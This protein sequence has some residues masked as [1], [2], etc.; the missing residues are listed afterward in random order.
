MK[1]RKKVNLQER[2]S[3]FTVCLIL[4][5]VLLCSLLYYHTLSNTIEKQLSKRALNVATTIAL[6]PEIRDAFYTE[7]P[8][9]IIQPIVEQIREKIDAEYI[10]VGNKDGIRYSHPIPE[11]IGKQMIGGDNAKALKE[12]RSYTSIATGSL[13]LSLRGKVPIKGQNGEI[14]G[15]VSVGFLIEDVHHLVSKHAKPIVWI[16]LC[17]LLIGMIGSI[18]LVKSIKKIMFGLEPEEIST[19]LK[20]RNAVIESVRE[21]IMVINNQEEIII[22]NQTAYDILSL[23]PNQAVVGKRVFDIIPNATMLEVLQ[24]G[25]EQ[26]DRQMV[27]RNKI[28]IANQLPV[29]SGEDVIGVV[30]SFR[31]KSEIDQLIEELSQANRYNEALRAQ[32]HEFTN[33]LYTISGLI[34]LGSNEEALVLIHNETENNND[35]V[36]FLMKNIKDPWLGGILLGY[37]NRA[38]ELKIHF[39]IDRESSLEELPRHFD[40]SNFVSILGNLITNAFESI[41][42]RPLKSK[43]VSLF[44]TDMGNDVIIEVEDS[45]PGIDDDL[46]PFIFQKGFSTKEGENR[47]IGLARVKELVT[48]MN[49]SITIEKGEYGGA[50][51]IVAI[52]KEKRGENND[53]Y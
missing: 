13:G 7:D 43:I 49:G 52:P 42:K 24:T 29:K 50:F 4:F 21:G 53:Y 37:Y 5:I 45:G 46:F 8:S 32:T 36:Q 25:E 30:S 16:A 11:R 23:D 27:F 15:V 14:I 39:V 44:I 51:F 1:K 10:V 48:E 35:F 17:A 18:F 20:Q 41:E 6:M 47:G 3:L 12:G 34:Q 38:K 2:I 40:S 9:V 19:L 33:L 28:I 26:L 22:L 31:L